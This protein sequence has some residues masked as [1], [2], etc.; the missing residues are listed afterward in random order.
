M[1]NHCRKT[2][3]DQPRQGQPI[4]AR[5]IQGLEQQGL[6]FDQ[7]TFMLRLTSRLE[8]K[9]LST[10]N[11]AHDPTGMARTQLTTQNNRVVKREV[12]EILILYG[13][14]QD[15]FAAIAAHELGHVWLFLHEYPELVP[16]VKEGFCELCAYLWLQTLKTPDAMYRLHLMEQNDDPVYGRGFQMAL[17]SFK[18]N[19]LN[20][21]TRALQAQ[22]RFP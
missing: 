7:K 6:E 3:I 9:Q 13:L 12:Q 16:D 19:K 4:L 21:L 14:P 18:H 11:Y 22:G 20:G 8:L 5:V 2:A 10:K 1:C 17:A 15:H